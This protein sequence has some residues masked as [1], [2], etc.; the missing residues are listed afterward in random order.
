MTP[1]NPCPREPSLQSPQRAFYSGAIQANEDRK[2]NLGWLGSSRLKAGE[3]LKGQPQRRN[4]ADL[5]GELGSRS[6]APNHLVQ[7]QSLFVVSSPQGLFRT[8]VL[9]EGEAPAEPVPQ[10]PA[11]RQEPRT[12]TSGTDSQAIRILYGTHS[13]EM[14][15]DANQ[16][17]GRDGIRGR[18][19][20]R[21]SGNRGGSG[22]ALEGLPHSSRHRKWLIVCQLLV[23]TCPS[24]RLWSAVGR[25]ATAFIDSM[26]PSELI[27]VSR[28][29]PKKSAREPSFLARKEQSGNMPIAIWHSFCSIT[30]SWLRR[31][32]K[33]EES[34][35]G[36][37]LPRDVDKH[38]PHWRQPLH[39]RGS[40][41][42]PKGERDAS[43]DPPL[44]LSRTY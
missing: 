22:S 25:S 15:V 35:S 38:P 42:P 21:E 27:N 11:A 4:R 41:P 31:K 36:L 16:K 23:R 2:S 13:S 32:Q 39:S 26:N 44:A 14:R 19:Q 34:Y 6:R 24:N 33:L 29:N 7:L 28:E 5:T 9:R 17:K 10:H 8:V 20:P 3:P 12:P 1:D 37:N 30:R 40:A 43:H 18:R